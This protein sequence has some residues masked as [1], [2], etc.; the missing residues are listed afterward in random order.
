MM[1][2][3][4]L[5]VLVVNAVYSIRKIAEDW[6]GGRR[7]WAAIGLFGLAGLYGLIGWAAYDALSTTVHAVARHYAR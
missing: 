4:L 3:L 5:L 1:L 7:D 6:R 2:E